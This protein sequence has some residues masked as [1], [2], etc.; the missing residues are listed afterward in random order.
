MLSSLYHGF[1]KLSL[2]EFI[3]YFFNIRWIYKFFIFKSQDHNFY[4]AF[5]HAVDYLVL[6]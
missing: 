4:G 3:L 5:T 6:Q 2:L 1:F